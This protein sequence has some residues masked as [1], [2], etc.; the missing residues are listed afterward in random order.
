MK[1]RGGVALERLRLV[2]VGTR[3]NRFFRDVNRLFH[4]PS[5][6]SSH[7][8]VVGTCGHLEEKR[9]EDD[10]HLPDEPEEEGGAEIDGEPI[11]LIIAA[12]PHEC[13]ADVEGGRDESTG[14]DESYGHVALQ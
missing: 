9:V 8:V 12:A 4:P 13:G 2:V 11:L 5:S 7:L 14:L 1:P 6:L 3:V 10:A